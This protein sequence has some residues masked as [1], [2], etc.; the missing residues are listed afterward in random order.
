MPFK[1]IVHVTETFETEPEALEKY[2]EVTGEL[3]NHPELHIN[4]QIVKKLTGFSP[5][6]PNGHEVPA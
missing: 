4:G 2:D 6:N 5:E 1:M 3:R